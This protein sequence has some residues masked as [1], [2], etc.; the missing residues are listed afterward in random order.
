MRVILMAMSMFF[1]FLQY[2]SADEIAKVIKL[3]YLQNIL[4]HHSDTLYVVNFWATWCKPCIEELPH[5]EEVNKTLYKKPVKVLLISLDFLQEREKTLIPFLQRKQIQSEVYLLD[6][7]NPNEW[8]DTISPEWSG[9][10]PATLF[11]YNKMNVKAFYEKQFENSE[12]QSI[13]QS[14][15]EK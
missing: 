2:S 4:N 5:F 12:L 3:P 8:I 9:A 11:V 6:A 1:I 10:L 14:I 15:L 13:I 7:V